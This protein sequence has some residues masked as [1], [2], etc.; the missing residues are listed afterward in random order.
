[1]GREE[2]ILKERLRKI[3]ELRK[4]GINPFP[5]YY[6]QENH[7]AELQ[8]KYKKLKNESRT[9]D[10]VKVAGRVIVIRDIGKLAFISLQDG[11]G[12]IQVQIQQE[13]TP[14]KEFDFFKKYIDSGDFIGVE[15]AITRTKRGELT[16]LAGKIELLSKSLRP[17]PEKWHGLQDKEERYRKRYLD[18]IMSPE[19]RGV[20]VKRS[21]I[22]NAIREFLNSRDYL[23]VDTPVLQPIYGGAAA[24]PF[25]THLNALDMKLYLRISNELYLKRLIVGG[26]ERVYEFA[27]DF[28]NEGIDRTHNPEF[29]QVEL[30]Q[31]YADYNEMMKICEELWGYVAKKVLGTTEI[32][33]QGNKINLK[34][35]WQRLS[36]K[37]AI[38][39]Y[40][41]IDVDSLDDEKLSEIIEKNR[42][43]SKGTIRGWMIA[44]IFEH[45]CEKHLIQPT[46]IYDYPEETTPLCKSKRGDSLTTLVERF[47]L[48]ILGMEIG[49]AY[50]E[51]NNPVKQEILLEQ[52]AKELKKGNE[53]ANPM[54]EDF[55]D[56]LEV[57][58]PPTG[59]LGIGIDRM[60]MLLT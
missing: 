19:V 60:V 8:E 45:F 34:A 36:M 29:T 24:K 14:E 22:I 13:L 58:M 11:S 15:G 51:L 54:D 41:K 49:N 26:F 12:K 16:V 27:R 32:D 53:E 9:K 4:V 52:Q 39:K 55:V 18:L 1:M 48:Y 47:E 57:G 25:L 30:Y 17:L 50:S 37:E 42:I 23:E 21:K 28:R 44:S 3:E 46:F 56:A 31:A 33:Y 7:A 5:Y 6:N 43:K 35:P 10:N 40:A 38:K 2:E 20:F 59:G